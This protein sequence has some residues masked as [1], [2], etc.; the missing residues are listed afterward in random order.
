MLLQ[1]DD[2]WL[3]LNDPVLNR[4]IA[5]AP[6]G[7]PTLAVARARVNGADAAFNGTPGLI[8]LTTTV[9][10]TGSGLYGVSPTRS[11][12]A[13]PSLGWLLD[14]YG[15]H[16]PQKNA[17]KA[18]IAVAQAKL[19]AARL[20]LLYNLGNAYVEPRYRQTVLT[21]QDQE[22]PSRRQTLA[23]TQTMVEGRAATR[24]DIA[25]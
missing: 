2:W 22:M 5:T 11:S 18:G 14:P 13:Q 9:S 8:N 12:T 21:L 25:R 17:A 23:M 10:V 3:R 16:R 7:N 4:L 6:A 19:N 24:L 15:A 1:N 20:L